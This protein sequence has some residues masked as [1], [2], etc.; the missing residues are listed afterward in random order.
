MRRKRN[1]A[2]GNLFILMIFVTL[3]ITFITFF[4]YRNATSLIKEESCKNNM[5]QA[6]QVQ[7][8]LLKTIS[9]ADRL[10][11]AIGV[12]D[13]TKVFWYNAHPELLYDDFYR[14]LGSILTS[15]VYSMRDF[16]FSVMLYAPEFGRVQSEVMDTP[17]I[18]RDTESDRLQNAEWIALLEDVEEGKTKTQLVLR[19]AYNG[20]PYVMTVI[21]QIRSGAGWGAV[22][23]DVDLAK[24]YTQICNEAA[25]DTKVWV[26]DK[27][28]RVVVHEKKN[29]LY[30]DA[31]KFEMLQFFE[32]V[33][34]EVSFLSENSKIPI[35]YAQRYVEE[36]GF[37]IVTVTELTG[38]NYILLE[39]RLNAVYI[40]LGCVLLSGMVLCVY[41][42][43]TKKSMKDILYRLLNPIDFQEYLSDSEKEVQEVADYIVSNLQQNAALEK[44]LEERVHMLKETQ[45]QALKAQINPHFLFNTLNIIVMLIDEEI[46]DSQAAQVTMALAEVLRYSLADEDLVSLFEELEHTKKY[47]SILEQ[48]YKG[49]FG[50][51]FDISEDIM[52]VRV[53]RLIL[54]PLIENAVFHGISAKDDVKDGEL[55]ISGHKE[56]YTFEGEEV[57]VVRIDVVDNGRGM[58]AQKVEELLNAVREEKISMNHIGVQN[59]AKRLALLFPKHSK[60]EIYSDVGK[61]TTVSCIFPYS[62]LFDKE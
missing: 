11:G 14:S 56:L 52:E 30:A 28:G 35:A 61:G 46:E 47:L 43:L 32:K 31:G 27:E 49:K 19:G 62:N 6:I 40:G 18:L 9:Q 1:T 59:V 20:Y 42:Y 15:Y 44:R 37:Y 29:E 58:H 53:P 45:I 38:L 24:L 50:V 34:E 22:A 41:A 7:E 25:T 17:Y 48:R 39:E 13:E 5:Y 60:V 26:L 3:L 16:I 33:P 2:W 21:K 36:Y 23:I 4:A 57:W 8:N 10:A 54:Q 51:C 12:A 55:T